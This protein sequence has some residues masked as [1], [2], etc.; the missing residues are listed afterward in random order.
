MKWIKLIAF[1]TAALVLGLSVGSLV[2]SFQAVQS[3]ASG[4]GIGFEKSGAIVF[5]MIV[6][7]FIIIASVEIMRATLQK[8][9]KGYPWFLVGAATLGSVVLNVLHAPQN[10]LAQVLHGI[11]PVALALSFHLL[12]RQI[13]KGV[14]R[15]EKQESLEDLQNQIKT[16]RAA[17][18][19]IQNQNETAQ[20]DF[21]DNQRRR[22]DKLTQLDETIKTTTQARRAAERQLETVNGEI[23]ATLARLHEIET[24]GG[25]MVP[26]RREV[27]RR[28]N[29]IGIPFADIARA[30]GVSDRTVQRDIAAAND[31]PA[32]TSDNQRHA[33][34]TAPAEPVMVHSQNGTGKNGHH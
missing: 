25:D 34:D 11:P 8:E 28:L 30:L 10:L 24:S 33:S 23:G 27:A 14:Q 26:W 32:T 9:G 21:E 19:D 22:V 20:A 16:R 12:I 29:D 31:T 2:L 6:D 5:A 7:G 3:L 13:E 4:P 1:I 18:V 15:I 17:L